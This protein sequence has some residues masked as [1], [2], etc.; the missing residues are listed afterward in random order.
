V[1]WS[2]TPNIGGERGPGKGKERRN[3]E[4]GSSGCRYKSNWGEKRG[5][6][7]LHSVGE[8]E[9]MGN[10]IAATQEGR[11]SRLEGTGNVKR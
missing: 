3:V 2:K 7:Q 10:Y 8:K 6:T 5:L 9:G 4:E 1:D 11:K